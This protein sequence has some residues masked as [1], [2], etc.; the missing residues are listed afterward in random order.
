MSTTRTARFVCYAALLFAARIPAVAQNHFTDADADGIKAFLHATFS[1][2]NTN[3]CMV[4]GLVDERGSKVFK[5]GMLDNG[6]GQEANGDTVFEIASMTKTFTALLLVDM[7]E[8]GQMKLDDPVAKY[9]P[10]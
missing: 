4:I 7:V 6:T 9:L 10:E 2:T 3:T 5:A 8:R 1:G